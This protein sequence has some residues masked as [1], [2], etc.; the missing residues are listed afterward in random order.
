MT[1]IPYA[2][3][4]FYPDGLTALLRY[5]LTHR[6][7]RLWVGAILTILERGGRAHG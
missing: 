6:H 3:N 2:S 7:S 1:N 4:L 5:G